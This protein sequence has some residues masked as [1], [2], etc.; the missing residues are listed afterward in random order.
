MSSERLRWC[1]DPWAQYGPGPWYGIWVRE[2]GGG[3]GHYLQLSDGERFK[4]KSRAEAEAKL[5]EF[6]NLRANGAT[7]ASNFL[8]SGLEHA[9]LT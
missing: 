2:P 4:A 6:D 8:G 3:A 5:A 1:K 7:A 9:T